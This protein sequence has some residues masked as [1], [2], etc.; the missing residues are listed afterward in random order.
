MQT[1]I[2]SVKNEIRRVA[3][4]SGRG[5]VLQSR[6]FN[7]RLDQHMVLLDFEV[8]NGT[9]V[10][11]GYGY[12]ALTENERNTTKSRLKVLFPADI[13][14]RSAAVV[15]GAGTAS[16]TYFRVSDNDYR[17]VSSLTEY[18]ISNAGG[19][20]ILSQDGVELFNAGNSTDDP[21]DHSNW[22]TTLANHVI[23]ISGTL[24]P[25]INGL[26]LFRVNDFGGKPKWTSDGN[27]LPPAAGTWWS[28]SWEDSSYWMVRRFVNGDYVADT[29]EW[30]S[31]ENV[32]TPDL[33]VGSWTNNGTTGQPSF[34]LDVALAVNSVTEEPSVATPR[35]RERTTRIRNLNELVCDAVETRKLVPIGTAADSGTNIWESRV[36]PYDEWHEEKVTITATSLNT[37]EEQEW[38][39]NLRQYVT[40]T[41]EPVQ[42][43]GTPSTTINAGTVTHIRFQE[44]RCGWWL[45][46]TE[47][48]SST[49]PQYYSSENFYWP[50]VASN[51]QTPFFD[52]V[53]GD[54]GSDPDYFLK[55]AT[56]VDIKE[57]YSDA[58]KV[59][60]NGVFKL[61]VVDGDI[62][63]DKMIPKAI[64]HDGIIQ[65]FKLGPTLHE[66][67]TMTENITNHPTIVAKS[68]SSTYPATVPTDWPATITR[69]FVQPMRG[70]YL[71]LTKTY[72]N[73]E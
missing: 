45:K 4:L 69:T 65:D 59:R 16:G 61:T 30:F 35:F 14:N 8:A 33:V 7:D 15:S 53:E 57:A 41:Q 36:E 27:E 10:N 55:Y 51:A 22:T 70:G 39:E 24:D 46:I 67:F 49:I 37:L 29:K 17:K 13:D 68:R 50:P 42:V 40:V 48:F 6:V 32:A 34:T 72:Y 20:W 1:Y 11:A 2:N 28:V 47:T 52:P 56:S 73:P 25:D 31:Y 63:N 58:T 62:V 66:A 26:R 71:V 44:I 38:D 19:N 43:L 54:G 64:N 23:Q 3:K 5:P 12:F 18:K 60:I 21:W 9:H